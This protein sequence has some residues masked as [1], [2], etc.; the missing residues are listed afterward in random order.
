MKVGVKVVLVIGIALLTIGGVYGG[1]VIN[2]TNKKKHGY[3][4]QEEI[5]TITPKELIVRAKCAWDYAGKGNRNADEILSG[6]RQVI[7][8]RSMEDPNNVELLYAL[9]LVTNDNSRELRM[10]KAFALSTNDKSPDVLSDLYLNYLNSPESNA[11]GKARSVAMYKINSKIEISDRMI[12]FGL[13]RQSTLGLGKTGNLDYISEM[14]DIAALEEKLIVDGMIKGREDEVKKMLEEDKKIAS[15][16]ELRPKLEALES[17]KSKLESEMNQY[18]TDLKKVN[19]KQG[20]LTFGIRADGTKG[21]MSVEERFFDKNAL[22]KAK[23]LEVN[24]L[25]KQLGITPYSDEELARYDGNLVEYLAKDSQSDASVEDSLL[26]NEVAKDAGCSVGTLLEI[27]KTHPTFARQLK[28]IL[29]DRRIHLNMEKQ[30][31]Q[32]IPR[33]TRNEIQ[34][35]IQTSKMPAGI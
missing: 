5:E 23:M 24:E 4:Y 32:H 15:L 14:A 17:E 1:F 13:L 29:A 31:Q 2:K 33:D 28:T 16:D 20:D 19:A 10:L 30:T 8:W 7:E 26:L 11:R 18:V 34:L 3:V 21:F 9:A 22:V 6:T 25:R 35:L 27:A 12:I